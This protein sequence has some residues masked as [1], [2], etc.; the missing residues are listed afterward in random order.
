MDYGSGEAAEKLRAARQQI[1][2]I[3]AQWQAEGLDTSPLAAPLL[4]LQEA[5]AAVEARAEA[6]KFRALSRELRNHF[7]AVRVSGAGLETE[8]NPVNRLRWLDMIEQ[9]ADRFLETLD[10]MEQAPPAT[11]PTPPKAE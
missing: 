9:A 10:R 3:A 7:N 5:I 1:T 11:P 8:D 6:D 2:H 4:M